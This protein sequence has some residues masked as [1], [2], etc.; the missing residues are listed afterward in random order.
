MTFLNIKIITYNCLIITIVQRS[1]FRYR[2]KNRKRLNDNK[3]R[4][5]L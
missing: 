2:I 4:K 1:K 5:C 3:N